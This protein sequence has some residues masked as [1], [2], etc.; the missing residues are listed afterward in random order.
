[1]PQRES[2]YSAMH[3]YHQCD[4]EQTFLHRGDICGQA[5]MKPLF[6]FSEAC[7]DA[8]SHQAKHLFPVSLPSP[9]LKRRLKW[10]DLGDN[11]LNAVRLQ[12]EVHA[13]SFDLHWDFHLKASPGQPQK[14]D[15][16]RSFDI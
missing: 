9:F 16:V 8:A 13:S 5:V 2:Q 12:R 7:V 11:T 15:Y 14:I 10:E 4:S 6:S 1:M 3:P